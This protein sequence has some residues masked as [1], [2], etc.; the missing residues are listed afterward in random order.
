MVRSS[1]TSTLPNYC[2]LLRSAVFRSFLSTETCSVSA[3]SPQ[4]HV[5]LCGFTFRGFSYPQSTSA[6]K[7]QMESARNKQFT[8]FKLCTFLSSVMKSHTVP[9]LRLTP[10]HH[11]RHG[12]VIQDHPKCTTLFLT[13]GQ[14]NGSPTVRGTAS[15]ILLTASHYGGI[16]SSDVVTRRGAMRTVQ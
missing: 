3:V 12:S 5:I 4:H 13:Y 16:L 15:V 2:I 6:Q 1:Q 8:S 14:V 11:H 7:C 9:R 10:T